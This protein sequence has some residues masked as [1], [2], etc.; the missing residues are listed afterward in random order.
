MIRL[1]E[2][3]EQKRQLLALCRESAFGCKIASVVKAYGFDKGFACFWLDEEAD[4]VFCL[5]DDV[6]MLSGN[7]GDAEETRQFLRM[8]GVRTVHCSAAN[9]ERLGW[10]PAATGDVLC[11]RAPEGAPGPESREEVPIR[12]LYALLEETGM[13]EEFE[14]F[15]LDLSHRLRHGAARAFWVRREDE[16][17]ACA[18]VSAI[19]E[20]AVLLSVVA[21]RED[22]RRQ[23]LGSE[24]VRQV[25]AAF[26]GKTVYV[27]REKD[28]HQ[29]FYSGLGYTITDRWATAER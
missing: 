22:L 23:G 28:R 4:T 12:E 15:Y 14:P 11:K 18:I 5:A 24:M 9:M 17:G 29:A 8:V 21:V 2:T 27:F 20:G 6:M 25:E 1:V 7:L 10:A 26:P 3:E 16:I 13:V 19:G